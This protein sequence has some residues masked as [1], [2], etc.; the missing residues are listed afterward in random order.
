MSFSARLRKFR[1]FCD[2]GVV[3]CESLKCICILCNT[4]V[5]PGYPEQL[6]KS[7]WQRELIAQVPG[8]KNCNK[9]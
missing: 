9:N 4:Y 7:F 2:G 1:V 6:L 5:Y 3:M 8:T